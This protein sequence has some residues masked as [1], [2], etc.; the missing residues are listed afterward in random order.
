MYKDLVQSDRFHQES[1]AVQEV[2]DVSD[3]VDSMEQEETIQDTR[4]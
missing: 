1:S 4:N 3:G 2:E